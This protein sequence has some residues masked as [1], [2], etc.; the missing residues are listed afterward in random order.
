VPLAR[1]P[2]VFDIPSIGG[3]DAHTVAVAGE[4][5]ADL[6][7]ILLRA[8]DVGV[9]ALDNVQQVHLIFYFGRLIGQGE[10]IIPAVAGKWQKCG[11]PLD[12]L[13]QTLYDRTY[14]GSTS[15]R[16]CCTI[17]NV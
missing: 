11:T 2:E 14:R 8:A 9:I 4:T 12:R 3:E 15:A 6:L 16:L 1:A 17:N 13:I 7:K 10:A 5:L